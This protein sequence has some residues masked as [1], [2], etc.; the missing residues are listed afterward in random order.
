MK[1][2]FHPSEGCC[3][4]RETTITCLSLLPVAIGRDADLDVKRYCEPI[5]Q[6]PIDVGQ[7]RMP[8]TNCL[9]AAA[10][11]SLLAL[12]FHPCSLSFFQKILKSVFTGDSTMI[13]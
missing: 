11:L 5:P 3:L 8:V 2:N 10:L 6:V 9:I 4:A 12:H 7:L 13:D 1:Y